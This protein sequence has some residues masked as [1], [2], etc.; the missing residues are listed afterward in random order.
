M[1]ISCT[2]FNKRRINESGIKK[3]RKL[4]GCFVERLRKVGRRNKIMPLAVPVPSVPLVTEN[5]KAVS[6]S[7]SSTSICSWE[8]S[9]STSASF[10][11]FQ[12]NAAYS[13]SI[14][15]IFSFSSTDQDTKHEIYTA[16]GEDIVGIFDIEDEDAFENY[17]TG[18]SECIYTSVETKKSSTSIS[19]TC[20]RETEIG[21]NKFVEQEMILPGEVP[22]KEYMTG[23]RF[24][25]LTKQHIQLPST[26]SIE[27]RCLHEWMQGNV[28]G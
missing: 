22:S 18:E 21:E 15:S 17:E 7:E 3:R 16:N 28:D 26:R 8:T 20:M 27:L 2:K 9:I 14:D 19:P 11:S 12:S 13:V 4:G 1:G 6:R 25:P 5:I 10:I 24:L 23:T